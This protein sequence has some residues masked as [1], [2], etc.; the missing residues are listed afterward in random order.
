MSSNDGRSVMFER[1]HRAALPAPQNQKNPR[2]PAELSSTG[3]RT[4]AHVRPSSITFSPSVVA[5]VI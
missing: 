5:R 4:A 1:R 3:L 2:R